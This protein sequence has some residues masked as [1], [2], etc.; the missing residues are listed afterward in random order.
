MGTGGL[1][2]GV[3]PAFCAIILSG[4]LPTRNLE[5]VALERFIEFFTEVAEEWSARLGREQ[6]TPETGAETFDVPEGLRV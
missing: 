6:T 4:Q 5:P 3:Q 2:L 1:L